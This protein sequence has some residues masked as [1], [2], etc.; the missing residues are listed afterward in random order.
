[1]SYMIKLY[2]S[3]RYLDFLINSLEISGDL[4]IGG[5]LTVN[6][7]SNVAVDETVTGDF[8]VE[9][10]TY[11]GDATTDSVY[12][13]GLVKKMILDNS[14]YLQGRNY[15]DSDNI[16]IVS[17]NASDEIDV[18]A[19]LN[20]GNIEA[21]PDSGAIVI[22]NQPVTS[23]L[24]AGI[25]VSGSIDINNTDILKVYAESDGAGGIQNTQVVVGKEFGTSSNPSLAFG[26]GDTGF[27]EISDD[28]LCV[29]ING[30]G[31][32]IFEGEYFYA[33]GSNNAA[34][35]STTP[36]YTTPVFLPSG[37]SD[38]DT[39]IG[40]GANN[41][42]SIIAGGTEVTRYTQHQF[43]TKRGIVRNTSSISGNHNLKDNEHIIFTDSSGGAITI[44][45]PTAQ[46]VDGR[47]IIIKDTGNAGTN[48]ITIAT[49]GSETID[50]NSTLVL[51]SD[52]AHTKLICDGT[53]WFV[54]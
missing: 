51:N 22:W 54:I 14:I 40:S 4:E 12:F 5:D 41:E 26:D 37:S 50:G 6:G 38:N 49:E 7:S 39:G 25:E 53:N 52:Y 10:D 19:T 30:S 36:G 27:Y 29:V 42:V 8:T 45:L 11:F 23:S 46:V 15:G 21:Y 3:K 2:E 16:N 1:M 17:I 28:K 18:G 48:N 34:I 9:G 33:G 32:F 31:N 24:S 20:V 43:Y 35:R 13:E 44:T 47:E